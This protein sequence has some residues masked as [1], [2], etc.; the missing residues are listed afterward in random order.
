MIIRPNNRST[1]NSWVDPQAMPEGENLKKYSVDITELV[2]SGRMDPV[3]GNEPHPDHY[4][5]FHPHNYYTTQT[6]VETQKPTEP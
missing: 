4:Q 2:K 6:Q 1:G 3:I 5:N